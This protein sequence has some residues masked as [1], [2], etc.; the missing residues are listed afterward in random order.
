MRRRACRSDSATGEESGDASRGG[1]GVGPRRARIPERVGTGRAGH[2]HRV[3]VASGHASRGPTSEGGTRT[4]HLH[5]GDDRQAE[6]RA[7]IHDGCGCGRA[8]AGDARIGL[9]TH[10]R[11][12]HARRQPSV[13]FGSRLL[14]A[15]GDGHDANGRARGHSPEIRRG[16]RSSSVRDA[17]YRAPVDGADDVH[18]PPEAAA[19][20]TRAVR[21]LVPAPRPAHGRPVPGRRQAAHD[22]VVR[23]GDPRVLRVHRGRARRCRELAGCA[24]A[25][26][27][28]RA[29]HARQRRRDR[30]RGWH[31]LGAERDRRDRGPQQVLPEFHLLESRG[32]PPGARPRRPHGNGRRRLSRCQ[33]LPVPVRPQESHDHLRR[34]QYLSGR[35]RG[36]RPGT[37]LRQGLRGVRHSGRAVRRG[38]RARGR[39]GAGSRGV[40]SGHVRVPEGPRGILQD[41][42]ADPVLRRLAARGHRQDLQAR[43]PPAVLAADRGAASEKRP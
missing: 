5:V 22:R 38:R 29:H 32:G 11:D 34:R 12:A 21:R 19:R 35:D 20:G 3:A 18:R 6:R 25:A 4:H 1:A 42:E 28:R 37:S 39:T 9:R 31:A 33:R 26:R 17:P 41:A 10:R 15:G 7:P 16:G 40:G 27:H 23:P 8:H 2:I 30:R 13:S 14:S 43:A 24:R 36:R